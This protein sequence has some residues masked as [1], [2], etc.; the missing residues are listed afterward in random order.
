MNPGGRSG[1]SGGV[2][3]G[4]HGSMDSLDSNTLSY[5]SNLS[6]GMFNF[7]NQFNL[8]LNEY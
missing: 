3:A 6:A 7:S 2:N 4:Y 5:D 8:C 1:L